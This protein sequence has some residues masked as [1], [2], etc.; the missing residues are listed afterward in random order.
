MLEIKKYQYANTN[1][2]HKFNIC[3]DDDNIYTR[4][5][6]LCLKK[7]EENRR[8]RRRNKLKKTNEIKI[9]NFSFTCYVNEMNNNKNS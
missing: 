2:D 8:Q 4:L 6:E 1:L 5:N 9:K 3:D 7:I